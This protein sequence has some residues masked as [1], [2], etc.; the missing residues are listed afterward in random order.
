MDTTS[1][2]KSK[3][4]SKL[5]KQRLKLADIKILPIDKFKEKKKKEEAARRKRKKNRE[6]EDELRDNP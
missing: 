3:L 6:A 5:A 4:K 1:P 2:I